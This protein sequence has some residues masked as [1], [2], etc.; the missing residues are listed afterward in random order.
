MK[1]GL[2]GTGAI[3]HKHAQAYRNIGFPVT[4]CTNASPESGKKFATQYNCEF[5]STLEELC[6]RADVDFVDVCTFPDFRLQPV[7]MCARYSKHIQVQKPIAINTAVAREMIVTARNAGI[8]L[9]VVSQHRFDDSSIFLAKAIADGRLGRLMEVDCYVKWFRSAEYYSRSIKGSWAVEGGGTLINQAIHQ[10]DILRWLAGP[11]RHVA[12][13]WQLG[14]L[15]KIESEDVVNA[16]LKF[17]SGATGVVQASTAYWP[18]YSERMEF[19]GTKGSAIV[20]G[21]KLTTWDVQDDQG[22]PAPLATKVESGA[23]D[24][25]AIS[26]Q[27]FERQ[28]LDFAKAIQTNR[29]PSVSGEEGLAALEIVEAIYDSCRRGERV[30]TPY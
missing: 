23:S 11:V 14:A 1:V 10:I 26:L 17:E 30:V 3:S 21:D 20:T 4:V 28:F 6:S 18:G 22:D 12:G 15:H 8:L 16:L 25:M 5:V 2:V 27:P 24:P 7:Q 13:D 19:H 9:N 29:K